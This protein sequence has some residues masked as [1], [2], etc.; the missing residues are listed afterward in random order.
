MILRE[1]RPSISAGHSSWR[2]DQRLAE[3]Q[4][5][6]SRFVLPVSQAIQECSNIEGH[7]VMLSEASLVVEL[8]SIANDSWISLLHLLAGLG[9]FF[10]TK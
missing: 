9:V 1:H 5:R 6:Q 10:E 4:S 7:V 8:A 3:L 2:C